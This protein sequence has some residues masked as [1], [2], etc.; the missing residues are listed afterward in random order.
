MT[1]DQGALFPAD[2]LPHGAGAVELATQRSL[3]AADLGPEYEGAGQAL[4]ALAWALDAARAA[5][6]FYG[7]AQAAPPYLEQAKALG[8]V[9]DDKPRG[10]GDDVESWLRSLATP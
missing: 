6:K 4:L 10:A 8:L 2:Q 1:A 3:Q 9:L 5:G 7:V